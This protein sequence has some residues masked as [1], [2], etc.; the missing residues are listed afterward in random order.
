MH[1]LY[2]MVEKQDDGSYSFNQPVGDDA[3]FPLVDV[4]LDTGMINSLL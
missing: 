4:E 3:R 2:E 1:G